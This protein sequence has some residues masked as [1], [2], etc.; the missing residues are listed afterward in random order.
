MNDDARATALAGR[1]ERRPPRQDAVRNRRKLLRAVGEAL[2]T[3]PDAVSMPL[4]AERAGLSVATAYRYF[5][6]LEDVLTSYVRELVIDLRDYSHDSPKTGSALF[7]DVVA[8]WVRSLLAH[9]PAIVQLRSHRGF[10]RRLRAGEELISVLRDAWER[11]IRGVLRQLDIGD[12]HFNHAL[13]LYNVLFDPREVFDLIDAGMEEDEAV[14]QLS[15]AFYGALQG[16]AHPG[17]RAAQ[18][19]AAAAAD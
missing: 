17:L 6:S 19:R 13:F 10:L 5:P 4:I 2:S 14:A 8:Y 11:P 7:E 9:G 18:A 3:E 16:W 1:R 15:G 12:E